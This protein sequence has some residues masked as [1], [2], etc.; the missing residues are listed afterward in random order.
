M[1]DKKNGGTK[2]ASESGETLEQLAE[3]LGL[4]DAEGALDL[5]AAKRTQAKAA[6]AP[7]AD[8]KK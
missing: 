1:A 6:P 5:D 4:R 2:A 3:R 8:A 7:K